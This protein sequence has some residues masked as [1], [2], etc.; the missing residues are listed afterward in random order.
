M[1]AQ[2]REHLPV[3]RR[4]AADGAQ[5][6]GGVA[7]ELA[8]LLELARLGYTKGVV[9]WLDEWVRQRPEQAAFAQG[10]RTLARE[11]RFEA[12][13]QRLLQAS[14]RTPPSP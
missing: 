12:I 14:G 5:A 9:Q 1:L 11:F 4:C 13:E 8:P 7:G 3:G 10:L 2:H 6:P